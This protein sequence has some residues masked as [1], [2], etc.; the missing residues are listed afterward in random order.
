M[1][2]R[3]LLHII[4][5]LWLVACTAGHDTRQNREL[6]VSIEPQRY[7]LERIAG[8]KWKVTTLMSRGEDPENFDPTLSDLRSLHSSGAYFRVGTLAF[9]DE[10]VAR[11]GGELPTV[12]TGKGIARLE[13]THGECHDHHHRH[14]HDEDHEHEDDPHIWASIA[15]MKVMAANMLEAM[16]EIDPADSALYRANY[17][18]LSARLDSCGSAIDNTLSDSRGATFMVWHPS[19]SYFAR[20]YG[21]NQLTIGMSNKEMSVSAFRHKI[22]DAR[23]QGAGLFLLQ[24]D[25]DAGRSASIASA[26]GATSLTVNT[27]A[28]D[29][30]SELVRIARQIKNSRK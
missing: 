12:D 30:P 17:L 24:S 15:N 28:Y 22:D 29:L 8:P 6:T 16:I 7:L 14:D 18:K 10:L 5:V 2:L 23:Q 25:F 3:A 20:D 4:P 19:L 1:K 26:A 9:E 13:G 11:A 27:L 21:L